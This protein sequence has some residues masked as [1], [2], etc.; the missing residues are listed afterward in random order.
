[1]TF[2]WTDKELNQE[3]SEAV[4]EEGS[5]FLVACPGSGK[6]RTLTYKIAYELSRLKSQ[7]Q[8]IVAFTYTNRAAEEI[9][10]RIE[11]LGI[12]TTRLWIGTIHSF[13]LEWILKPY[14]IYEP[15]L[16]RGF[17]IMDGH[18]Q[19]VLVGLLCTQMGVNSFF[20]GYFATE[21]GYQLSCS[22]KRKHVSLHA[23][24]RRYFEY[25]A[26]N[27][28]L[29]FEQ[30]LQYAWRLLSSKPEISRILANLFPLILVDEFQ[31]TKK[32]Q[33]SMLGAILRA[34]AGRTKI[35]IVG[36]PNQAIYGSLGGFAMS[37][38]EFKRLCGLPLVERE[39]SGNYRSSARIIDYFSNY[40]VFPTKIYP[41]SK[42]KAFP[43]L[44]TFNKV[45]DKEDVVD[46][47]VGLIKQALATGTPQNQICVL[48]PWWIHLAPMTRRL[49]AALPNCEF[50]GPGMVPFSRDQEN[51]WY[52]L[53]R[54]ALTQ[55]SPTQYARRRRWAA[56][57]IRDLDSEGVSVAHITVKILLR[58]SNSIS[59]AQ[60][61]GLFYLKEYFD[62]LMERLKIDWRSYAFLVDHHKG[63]F[64][65]S[66]ARL[67]KLGADGV[68]FRDIDFFRKVFRPRS[69]INV[70]TI[71]GVK[72]AEFDVVIA[73]GLLQGLVPNDNDEDGE[74]TAKKMLYVIGSRA[75]KHLHLMSESGRTGRG[76]ELT[77]TDV[78][79]E[80]YFPYSPL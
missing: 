53:S 50:D 78:L 60:R 15:D 74:A 8:Y 80:C 47:V 30:I 33:Y 56:E 71:H 10:E 3:Q 1:M 34:G 46:A 11:N 16:A 72:G 7:K 43:S 48:A 41:A 25:L 42:G 31:D 57:V 69:G 66:E 61:D 13:C 51:F 58:E 9:Q 17:S 2:T 64:D 12:D 19:D 75:K 77:P 73:Y 14:A 68:N 67:K 5:V 37:A 29:D 44:I 36:D 6:T 76:R 40:N 21:N 20:C 39:L 62:A 18:E 79:D 63:F 35:F 28:V 38:A 27:R 52:R 70:N 65:G 26:E 24:Y 59:I 55:A 32:I 23:L 45:L 22:D 4:L 54:I 49:V